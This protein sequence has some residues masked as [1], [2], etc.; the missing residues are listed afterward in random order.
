VQVTDNLGASAVAGATVNITNV[1]PTVT[2]LTAAPANALTGQGVT[3]TGTATDPSPPDTSAGFTW[4]FD[5][6]SGFGAFG[7]NGFVTSF[8]ACGT[9]S[10]AAE[11]QDKDGGVSAPF[12]SPAAVHVFSAAFRPPIDPDSLNLVQRG[13]VVPVKVTVGCNGFL[14]GLQPS[15]SI[16]T[17]DY[18]PNVDPDD[19]SYEVGDSASDADTSGV[20]REVD[21][22]YRYNLLVPNGPAG[23]I[24]T[25]LIRPFGGTTPVM[26]ALL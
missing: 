26:Y 23:T 21:S 25:V 18:D 4:A 12:T 10:V 9:Y 22:H 16:R 13:Q 6:G 8:A 14:S 17:G 7:S 2:S 19:P 3:L 20:M 24:Y 15:I 1:A 11:A 5:T